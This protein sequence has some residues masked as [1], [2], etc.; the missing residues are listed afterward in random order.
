MTFFVHDSSQRQP[1]LDALSPVAPPPPL[2][3]NDHTP[4]QGSLRHPI[5]APCLQQLLTQPSKDTFPAVEEAT[6]PPKERE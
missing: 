6:H 3:T 5:T 4:A 2:L 1:E